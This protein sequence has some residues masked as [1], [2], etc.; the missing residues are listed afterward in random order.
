MSALLNRALLAPALSEF[1]HLLPSPPALFQ[2]LPSLFRRPRRA[3]DYLHRELLALS[4]G[5]AQEIRCILLRDPEGS[6]GGA[7]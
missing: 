2:R 1:R 4:P 5:Q 6:D 3:S 7:R